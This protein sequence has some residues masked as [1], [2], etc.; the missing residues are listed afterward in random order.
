MKPR[1]PLVV[2][3]NRSGAGSHSKSIKV[4]RTSE[5]VFLKKSLKDFV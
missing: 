4:K 1:N 3:A 2:L 5:K